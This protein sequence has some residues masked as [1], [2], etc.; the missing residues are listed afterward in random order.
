LRAAEKLVVTA[1]AA[2]TTAGPGA[3]AAAAAVEPVMVDVAA[4]GLLTAAT[5]DAIIFYYLL[6]SVSS[7][8]VI[9]LFALCGGRTRCAA[10]KENII[11]TTAKHSDN[12]IVK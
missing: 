1:A 8:R 9:R 2:E 6:C 5:I 4:L 7:A 3:A 10:R 12:N 11:A